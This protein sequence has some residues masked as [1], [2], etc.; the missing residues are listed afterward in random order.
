MKHP[1]V[2]LPSDRRAERARALQ[3][4]VARFQVWQRSVQFTTVIPPRRRP[5]HPAGAPPRSR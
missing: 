5:H 2:S 4:T 1:V 3:G